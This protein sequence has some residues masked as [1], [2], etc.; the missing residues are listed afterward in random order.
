MPL[1]KGTTQKPLR[2]RHLIGQGKPRERESRF[3]SGRWVINPGPE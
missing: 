3:R 2:Y 1:M